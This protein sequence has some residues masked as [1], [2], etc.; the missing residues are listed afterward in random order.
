VV[1]GLAMSCDDGAR[2]QTI[3]THIYILRIFSWRR[4]MVAIGAAS[5]FAVLTAP[6]STSRGRQGENDN[7]PRGGIIF[8]DA[9]LP[10]NRATIEKGTCRCDRG[11]WDVLIFKKGSFRRA[12]PAPTC[13]RLT[14][15]AFCQ[16][17]PHLRS[18][19]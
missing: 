18:R 3:S 5:L 19:G 13:S 17:K 14:K 11:Q 6:W 10:G 15:L 2:V 8:P 12:P 9:E 7:P 1:T 16:L 4:V